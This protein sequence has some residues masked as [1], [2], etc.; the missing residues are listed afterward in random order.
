MTIAVCVSGISSRVP[1]YKKV[2]ELQK[3]VFPYKFFFQQW[4]GYPKPDVK[5]CLFTQE[6]TWDYHV[7]TE[8]KVKPECKISTKTCNTQ[9]KIKINENSQNLHKNRVKPG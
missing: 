1:E 8:A 5:N 6:P 3:R 9:K 7:I 2:I 4:E